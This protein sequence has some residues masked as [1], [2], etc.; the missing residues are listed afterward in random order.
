MT[1]SG[2]ADGTQDS[3]NQGG[4]NVGGGLGL[5][6]RAL[7]LIGGVLLVYQVLAIAW[8]V[9]SSANQA[10]ETLAARADM[11]AS[12]QARAAAIPLYDFDTE[13]VREVAKAP[14]SD[15]DFLGA[16][17]RDDKAKVVAEVGDTKAAKG[18]IE[19]VKPIVGGQAGQR[20]TIGE[21]VLRL[22]TDRVEARVTADAVTQIVVGAVAFL[23]IMAALYLVVSAITRPLMQITAMVGRLAQGDYA[24]AVPALDR[25]DEMGAMARTIDMLRQNAQ[26][27]EQLEAEKLARQAEEAQ[28]GERLTRLA[29]AFDRSVQA[30]VGEAST[31]ASQMKGSAG[32]MLE[33]A[34]RADQCNAS[35]AGAADETS[36]TVQTAS[37]AAEQ[38]TQSIRSIAESV[39]QSVAMS[40]QAIDRADASRKTVE[41]LAAGAAK[42]GEI[43]SL[44][45]SI[46]GQTNLLAL[47]ATIEAARAGEAGKGFAVVA[48][49]VKN[50]AS[51]TA[52]ATEEIATQIG[53]IQSV[54][55]ETVSAIGAITETIGQLSQRSAEIAASVQQQL[56]AT[57][58]IAEKVRTV[59]GEAD[60]VTRS[61]AVASGAS[62]E[63]AT[64]A[65]E[66]VEVAQTLQARFVDLRDEV[67]RF[68]A[69]I[70]AA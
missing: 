61:I 41:A 17:V 45:T 6:L 2:A 33:S 34:L 16:Q 43:T 21:F 40:A 14:S 53:A 46:A 50:L 8:G 20:K 54:T 9:H 28:R 63:V 67:Q 36:R 44:I 1:V 29:A 35:V 31:A 27:R 59:A 68:L 49:E 25:R 58:E 7:L 55:Q 11:V 32:S 3:G 57:G 66:S 22:R 39:K 18:F 62:S 60:T 26:H 13:Q 51:Q 5:R 37:A 48:S 12:L 19:V 69:S 38:L 47:N 56:A 24:V 70:K 10:K 42:I 64:A 15:P 52:K 23:A 4:R 65:R 30:T